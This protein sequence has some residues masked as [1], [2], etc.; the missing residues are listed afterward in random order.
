[1]DHVP[2]MLFL[3][4]DVTRDGI[5]S[6][7]DVTALVNIILGKAKYP[8]DNDKYDFEA[9]NVNGDEIISIAD[10]TALVNIILGK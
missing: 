1:M 9:A 2:V 3:V 7:A 5:V 4:G 6:I 8:N 10:V